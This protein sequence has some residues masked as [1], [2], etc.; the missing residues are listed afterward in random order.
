MPRRNTTRDLHSYDPRFK[1]VLIRGTQE[2][3]RITFATKGLAYAFQRKLNEFRRAFRAAN[4]NSAETNLLYRCKIS[5][6]PA[7]PNVVILTPHDSEF[8]DVLNQ[9]V[10][11]KEDA[12]LAHDPLDDL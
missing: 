12:T 11:E 2:V 6:R 3:H 1:E 10:G 9:L 4:P 8:D 7:E 5:R